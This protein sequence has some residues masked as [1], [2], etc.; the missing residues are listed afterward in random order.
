MEEV[1]STPVKGVEQKEFAL[2]IIRGLIVDLTDKE[3]EET[4]HEN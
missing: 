2:Q 3:D 1:E 4:E